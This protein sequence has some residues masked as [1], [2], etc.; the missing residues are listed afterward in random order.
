MPYAWGD[1]RYI[2]H[3]ALILVK[4][5]RRDGPTAWGITLWT[6][7]YMSFWGCAW[8]LWG[9]SGLLSPQHGVCNTKRVRPKR[10]GT[11]KQRSIAMRVREMRF[12]SE[13]G[14]ESRARGAC[15]LPEVGKGKSE[16][17]VLKLLI[18]LNTKYRSEPFNATTNQYCCYC[19]CCC[20][21]H[22]YK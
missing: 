1:A 22:S 7:I 18:L 12:E 10:R 19:C 16:L 13:G 5:P 4:R 14:L 8:S 17:Q 6:A 20:Y 15:C 11:A 21:C 2:L 3:C 9:H